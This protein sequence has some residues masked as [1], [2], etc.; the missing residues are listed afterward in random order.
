MTEGDMSTGICAEG[1]IVA[2]V[3]APRRRHR[4]GYYGCG[5]SRTGAAEVSIEYEL[6]VPGVE[7]VCEHGVKQKRCNHKVGADEDGVEGKKRK[8]L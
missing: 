1:S 3:R 7:N 8:C 6:S 4:W 2:C 5:G